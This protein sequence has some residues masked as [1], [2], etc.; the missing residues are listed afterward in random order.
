MSK[1]VKIDW[2]LLR[3]QKL[4]LIRTINQMPAG[5]RKDLANGLLNFIDI[6]QDVHAEKLGDDH[7]F[8]KPPSFDEVSM[9]LIKAMIAAEQEVRLRDVTLVIRPCYT[10]HGEGGKKYV[11]ESTP[12][13]AEFWTLYYRFPGEGSMALADFNT[14]EEAEEM[15]DKLERIF[16]MT[17]E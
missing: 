1:T 6:F 17:K 9:D 13:E 2:Q 4:W 12:E 10:V 8:G 15:K 3:A 5:H 16:N 14:D 11:E 7:V